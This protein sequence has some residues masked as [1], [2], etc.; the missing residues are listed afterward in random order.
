MRTQ[1]VTSPDSVQIAYEVQ[2]DGPALCLLHGF[3]GNRTIWSENGWIELLQSRF[4]VFAIDM[5]GCGE[6]EAPLDPQ[7][8]NVPAHCA[9]IEAVANACGIE[10]FLLWGWSFGA[11]VGLHMIANSSR[12]ER[13]VIAGTYFGRIFT[14]EY[15]QA[16]LNQASS[17]LEHARW[18][19]LASWRGV[20]PAMVRCPALIY[21]GTAD[22]N[23]LVQLEQQRPSIEEVGMRLHVFE[24]FK[25]GQLLTR[26]EVVSTIVLPFLDASA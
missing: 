12:I 22:G 25:H 1:F 7:A 24:G 23:V 17:P 19:G 15:V 13:A 14:K 11:T 26:Q 18:N 9:D 6:S 10:T 8:Y 3:S 16:R 20:E 2:G 4:T 21:T 5:R